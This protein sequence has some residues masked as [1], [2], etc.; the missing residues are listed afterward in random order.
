MELV[1]M[2]NFAESSSRF[3]KQI[4]DPLKNDGLAKWES[5]KLAITEKGKEK[6]KNEKCAQDDKQN[7]IY[8]RQCS[9]QIL[10]G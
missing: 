10:L 4:I 8:D 6:L 2:I 9:T 1:K 3:Q 5:G 7:E